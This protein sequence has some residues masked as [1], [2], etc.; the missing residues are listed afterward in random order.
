VDLEN[1]RVALVMPGRDVE[2]GFVNSGLA[3]FAYCLGSFERGL[4]AYVLEAPSDERRHDAVDRFRKVLAERDPVA[5]AD[6]KSF[7]P[8]M[9]TNVLEG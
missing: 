4:E 5:A 1:G 6:E 2:P 9:L 8:G 7:W 3:E